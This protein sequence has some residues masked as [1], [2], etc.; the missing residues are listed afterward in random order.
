[1][2]TRVQVTGLEP[3]LRAFIAAGNDAPR[4][5]MKALHEEASEAFLLSQEVVPVDLGVLRSSGKVHAPSF[6]GTTAEVEISYG[7]SAAHYAIYVHEL[8]PS[9]ARHAPPTRWKYLAHPVKVYAEGMADR[10]TTR[11]F[12]MIHRRF[13][14]G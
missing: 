4:F 3:L 11:V 7:G 6:R 1:M 10:M 14:I 9:R 8:P 2:A 5:A 12:D 13:E